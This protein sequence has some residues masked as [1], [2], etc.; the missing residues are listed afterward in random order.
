MISCTSLSFIYGS[1]NSFFAIALLVL[2]ELISQI[3]IFYIF[4][5]LAAV[6][7]FGVLDFDLKSFI[8][9]VFVKI[10]KGFFTEKSKKKSILS[11][12]NRVG[13]AVD[14]VIFV[15]FGLALRNPALLLHIE[16]I[17]AFGGVF[18]SI[19]VKYE[20]PCFLDFLSLV[21]FLGVLVVFEV[22]HVSFYLAVAYRT[23]FLEEFWGVWL[24][25]LSLKSMSLVSA[26][27]FMVGGISFDFFVVKSGVF[28]RFNQVVG[29]KIEMKIAKGKPGILFFGERKSFALRTLTLSG[30][31]P[32]SK[33]TRRKT[34]RDSKRPKIDKSPSYC[35][36]PVRF[37][38]KP[39]E[40][41]ILVERV[42]YKGKEQTHLVAYLTKKNNSKSTLK[43]FNMRT[44]K[45]DISLDFYV[46]DS[47]FG[48]QFYQQKY[49]QP[50]LV[51]I[52]GDHHVLLFIFRQK[53]RRGNRPLITVL[54]LDLSHTGEK[55]KG[56]TKSHPKI[57]K[58]KNLIFFTF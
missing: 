55:E 26:L 48:T 52:R 17:L 29:T 39:E 28:S 21:P 22:C 34:Q 53:G 20:N 19:L 35:K 37:S 15:L 6:E 27:V 1:L 41:V 12:K 45:V 30:I 14:G 9:P 25:L 47:V 5:C 58:V 24:G 23:E 10:I 3:M 40:R 18:C 51:Q 50:P 4:F 33:S 56:K 8:E 11:E 36:W 31:C 42:V 7:L 43:I 57:I 49:C 16:W 46:E 2:Q 13:L 38:H 32:S 54:D 44:K